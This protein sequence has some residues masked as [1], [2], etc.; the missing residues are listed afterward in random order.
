[1]RVYW[2]C[3]NAG[4]LAGLFYF[5]IRVRGKE[6]LRRPGP[7]ILAPVHRSNLD[8]PLISGWCPQRLRSLAKE[9]MFRGPVSRWFSSS[10]GAF[11][12]Q[13]DQLDRVALESARELLRRGEM[14]LVF[15]EGTR[16]SG[17]TVGDVHNGCSYLATVTGA[18][19]I[20]IGLAGTEEAM[21]PGAKIARPRRIVVTVGEPIEPEQ[22]TP[23]G[24]AGRDRRRALSERIRGEMQRLL[25]ESCEALEARS[26]GRRVRAILSRRSA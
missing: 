19:V 24:S 18:P 3:R 17:A 20:P 22:A 8:V 16:G 9:A 4:L 2:L 1:V 5:R 26:R 14:L 7:A 11:P 6:H 21:P 13:R 15:P 23:A 10:I 12:V 25:D